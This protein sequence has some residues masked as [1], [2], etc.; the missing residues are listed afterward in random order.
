MYRHYIIFNDLLCGDMGGES[1][2]LIDVATVQALSGVCIELYTCQQRS[3]KPKGGKA[4]APNKQAS[5]SGVIA[6]LLEL[7][8]QYPTSLFHI[9]NEVMTPQPILLDIPR[10]HS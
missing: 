9:T 1:V 8:D 5:I 10:F 2:S 6:P 3:I 7:S 4:G